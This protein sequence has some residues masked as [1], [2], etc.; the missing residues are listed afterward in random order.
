MKVETAHRR[1]IAPG[2]RVRFPINFTPAPALP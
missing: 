1:R 2:E